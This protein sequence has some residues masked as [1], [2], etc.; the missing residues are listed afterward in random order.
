[1]L[2]PKYARGNYQGGLGRLQHC[3]VL[4]AAPLL[5]KLGAGSQDQAQFLPNFVVPFVHCCML[6][7]SPVIG[8]PTPM[9]PPSNLLPHLS[10]STG[11]DFSSTCIEFM[12]TVHGRECRVLL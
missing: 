4:V 11:V 6:S 1:M 3:E 12:G 8:K 7:L 9:S 10:L 5:E 2:C